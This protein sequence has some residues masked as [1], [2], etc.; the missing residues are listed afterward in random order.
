MSLGL[1]QIE[2]GKVMDKN[3]KEQIEKVL[4][5]WTNLDEIL[6]RAG[7]MTADEQLTTLAVANAIA[8][9]IRTILNKN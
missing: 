5:K 7:E 6:L 4:D 8:R 3:I 1:I 2:K 9:E